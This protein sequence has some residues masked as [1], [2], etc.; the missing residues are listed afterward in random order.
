MPTGSLR[1]QIID[2][3]DCAIDGKLTINFEPAANSPGGTLMV[4]SFSAPGETD[5]IV[6]N[7]LC[8]GGPGTLYR[9]VITTGNFRPYSFFQLIQEERLNNPSESPVWMVVKPKR[10]SDITAPAFAA[11]SS[12]LST[13][14]NAATMQEASVED[15][16]LVGLQGEALYAGLGPLR[17]ACLLNV[18]TKASHASSD[19]CFSFFGSPRVLRQDRCFC[20]VDPLMPEFLRQSAK[21]KSAPNTLHQPLSNFRLEDSFKSRDAHANLQVTFMRHK[22]TGALC[23]DVDID[24]S[25]GI[26]HG[27]EVIRN[28]LIDG[29]TNPYLI[30]ELMILS[31]PVEKVLAPGYQFFLS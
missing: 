14:L 30:R 11:L 29:R 22:Q 3:L 12:P 20:S 1:L 10:V 9:V 8:R 7:L 2:L 17:K 15:R 27:F 13:F 21:F 18:F 25:S 6:E 5:F 28:A 16:D 19:G 23:A 26:E 24:E 31:D 4:V